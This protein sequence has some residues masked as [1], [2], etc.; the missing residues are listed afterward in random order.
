M[1]DRCLT[2]AVAHDRLRKAVGPLCVLMTGAKIN[3][4]PIN[5]NGNPIKIY[6]ILRY[7]DLFQAT[8]MMKS[9]VP[10]RIRE[11]LSSKRITVNALCKKINLKQSTV[12]GQL[13]GI[14]SLSMETVTAL[15]IEFPCL[16]A[17]W[18]MRGTGSMETQNEPADAE[19][20]E[21]Y[22]EQSREIYR[23]KQRIAELEGEGKNLA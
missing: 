7:L 20:K 23:L 1:R 13:N 2:F 5:C 15:L 10:Q 18:L 6:G 19:L 16:S 21:M 9:D 22:I 17:E 12:S 11:F 3:G 14:A 4:N 8:N